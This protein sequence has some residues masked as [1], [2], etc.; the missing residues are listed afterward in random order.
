MALPNFT[1]ERSLYRSSRHYRSS[2]LASIVG[3]V[4]P[5][6]GQPDGSYLQ[7]CS[8]CS[9]DGNILT[10]SCLDESG[11]SRQATLS[12]V[13]NCIGDIG[14]NNGYLNCF[15]NDCCC[16]FAV[17]ISASSRRYKE[18]IRDLSDETAEALLQL[19]PVT[20]R[21]RHTATD[22]T[23][24]PPRYGL[25]AEEVAELLPQVVARGAGGQVEG[26]DYFQFPALLV[27]ALQHQQTVIE[28]Q[29]QRLHA[30]ESRLA[31]AEVLCPSA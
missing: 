6:D 4:R 8:N 17:V 13:P 19:R 25:I 10:C 1:A 14:N 3:G 29:G 9:Y 23:N 12:S 20:F 27:S 31:T 22:G 16:N 7:S 26:I 18:D 5:S 28:A 24:Q 21:Y 2:A 15:Q 11:N 30:L